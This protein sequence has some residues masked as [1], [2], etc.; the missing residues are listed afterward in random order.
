M[1]PISTPGVASAW[2][3]SSTAITENAN[4]SSTARPS[5]R[6]TATT[7]SAIAAAAAS[8]PAVPTVTRWTIGGTWTITS[9]KRK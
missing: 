9:A 1:S 8:A 6:R 3:T 4:P 2:N 7:D 5:L